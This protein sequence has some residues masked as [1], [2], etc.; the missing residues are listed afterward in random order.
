MSIV[1]IVATM[2]IADPPD[3]VDAPLYTERPRLSVIGGTLV[4][5]RGTTFGAAWIIVGGFWTIRAKRISVSASLREASI[6][7]ALSSAA[8]RERRSLPFAINLPRK[9]E[10]A[11]K[12]TIGKTC[13]IHI[14]CV[15]TFLEMAALAILATD[16]CHVLI[17]VKVAIVRMPASAC[18]IVSVLRI[19]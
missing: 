6:L 4:G 1:C 16:R 18:A 3:E 2:S 5:D 14:S 11:E 10:A 8:C 17:R 19:V 7:L 12:A 9:K 15:L 13:S